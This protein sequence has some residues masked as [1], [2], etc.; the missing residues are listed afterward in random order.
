[1]EK[2][3]DT[4][5]AAKNFNKPA[6]IV[7][8]IAGLCFLIAKDF[9]N[10]FIFWGIALA[11]DP[12]NTSI[13]FEKRPLYQRAWLLIHVVLTLAPLAYMIAVK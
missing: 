11:L 6:Y 4:K 13:P 2:C 5:P 10:V 9:S 3:T 1:M 8:M 7:F 12:F